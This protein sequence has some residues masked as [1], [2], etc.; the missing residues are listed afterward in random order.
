[1]TG[2]TNLRNSVLTCDNT[3]IALNPGGF[4][5]VNN[6]LTT[7]NLIRTKN[8]VCVKS[9]KNSLSIRTRILNAVFWIIRSTLP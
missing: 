7:K 4:L 1:M 9:R 5:W 3:I 2:E 8:V 6:L